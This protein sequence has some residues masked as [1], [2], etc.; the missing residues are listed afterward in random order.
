VNIS[1]T[2]VTLWLSIGALAIVALFFVNAVVY[3]IRYGTFLRRASEERPVLKR[4]LATSDVISGAL[5][6]F[7]LLVVVG[8]PYVAPTSAFAAWLRE[9]YALFV[10]AV[11]SWFVALVIGIGPKM[12]ESLRRRPDA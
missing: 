8:A 11:W 3:R 2:T 9:P 1:M 6:C 5:V 4:K 7:A 10:Y 12:Y